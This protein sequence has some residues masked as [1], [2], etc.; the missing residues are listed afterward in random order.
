VPTIKEAVKDQGEG[1]RDERWVGRAQI[2]PKS[3]QTTNH[4]VFIL[5]CMIKLVSN[6]EVIQSY[7][8]NDLLYG[9][10]MLA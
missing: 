2:L 1:W 8:T 5:V 6:F 9:T 3:I 7:I 4:S 10:N